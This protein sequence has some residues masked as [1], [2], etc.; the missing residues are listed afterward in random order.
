MVIN[1]LIQNIPKG[2][3]IRLIGDDV[4]E[5][6]ELYCDLIDIENDISLS[7][8]VIKR[9]AD[10]LLINFNILKTWQNIKRMR[11]IPNRSPY[12]SKE[13][14]LKKM[15]RKKEGVKKSQRM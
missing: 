15:I 3:L 12:S 5:S 9:F 4:Y 7:D 1:N 6:I 2:T 11:T 14:N 10:D 8:I 13:E